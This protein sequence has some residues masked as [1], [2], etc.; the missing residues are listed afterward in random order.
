MMDS[1][2]HSI[3]AIFANENFLKNILSNRSLSE[4]L[5]STEF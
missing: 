2:L 5:F 4:L 3:F 1:K